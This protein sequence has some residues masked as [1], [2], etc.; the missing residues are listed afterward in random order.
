MTAKELEGLVE[1]QA[2][3]SFIYSLHERRDE[4]L[5][6]NEKLQIFQIFVRKV[7]LEK[8]LLR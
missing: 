2:T 6:T 7:C 5:S 3:M 4:K 8:F 1:E